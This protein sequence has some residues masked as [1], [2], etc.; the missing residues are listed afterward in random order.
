MKN[1]FRLWLNIVTIC[2]C[3]CAIA[4]GVYA[5]TNASLTVSGQI[6]FEAHG[7][8]FSAKARIKGYVTD[9]NDTSTYQKDYGE[10]INMSAEKEIELPDMY[11][12]DLVEATTVPPICIEITITNESLFAVEATLTLPT[13]ETLICGTCVVD[14]YQ[15]IN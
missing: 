1:K 3:V 14:L 9:S 11:F 12:T 10:Y 15:W 7:V 4:I 2:L 6:G 8:D 13:L 5:A